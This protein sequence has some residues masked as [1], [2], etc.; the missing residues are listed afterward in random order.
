MLSPNYPEIVSTT[1]CDMEMSSGAESFFL[2]E[3]CTTPIAVGH[4][5][6][7]GRLDFQARALSDDPLC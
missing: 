1:D 4:Q 5:H 2:G 6:L 3:A 7:K